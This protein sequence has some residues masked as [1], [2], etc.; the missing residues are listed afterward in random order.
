M[1]TASAL[2]MTI[3]NNKIIGVVLGKKIGAIECMARNEVRETG[4][5]AVGVRLE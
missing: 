2:M 5:Y 1:P 4:G 3:I